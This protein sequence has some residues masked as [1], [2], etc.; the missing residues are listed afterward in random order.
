MA[1]WLWL[2]GML[3]PV[4]GLALPAEPP[5]VVG[6]APPSTSHALGFQLSAY[7]TLGFLYRHYFDRHAL[8]VNLLPYV[9]E[10]GDKVFVS[11][12]AQWYYYAL[13]WSGAGQ[14][15]GLPTGALRMVAGGGASISREGDTIAVPSENCNTPA[16]QAIVGE[17]EPLKY[18]FSGAIGFGVDLGAPRRHGFSLGLDLLMTVLWDNEGFY[19]AYPLP[20]ASAVYNW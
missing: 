5:A 18:L 7:P 20:H 15:L 10:G 17:R 19:G 2:L 8:Q 11:V 6:N 1:R 14:G 3:L 9:L 13:E 16:C 12:G 4:S